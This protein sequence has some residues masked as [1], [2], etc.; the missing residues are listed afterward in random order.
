MVKTRVNDRTPRPQSL[1]FFPALQREGVPSRL[2]LFFDEGHWIGKPQ[3][4]GV[5]YREF[6]GWLDRYP[7]GDHGSER[8]GR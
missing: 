4:S 5:W 6:L 7:V 1:E 2:T 8:S 3:N